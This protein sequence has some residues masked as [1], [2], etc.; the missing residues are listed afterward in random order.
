MDTVEENGRDSPVLEEPFAPLYKIRVADAVKNGEAVQFTIKVHKVKDDEDGFVVRQF[1]DVEWLEHCLVTQQGVSGLIFPPLPP[2]PELDARS[3]EAKSKKQLG[4]ST[5]VIVGDEFQK[6]CRNL[7]KYLRL[8]ISHEVFGKERA[9]EN[10]LTLK[11]TYGNLRRQTELRLRKELMSRLSNVVG[12]VRKGGHR[13]IDEKFQQVRDW[14]S[15]Y[16]SALK[17]DSANFKKTVFA[18]RR[19][20]GAYGH[21]GT[22]LTSTSVYKDESSDKVDKL[23]GC[24][25]EAMND[26]KHGLEVLSTNDEKTLGFQLEFYCRYMDSLKEMLYRR[27]CLLVQYED[28]NKALEKAKPQKRQA[29]EEAQEAAQK[30]YNSCTDMARRELKTFEQERL[31][32]F[33]HGLSA[34]AESQV[35]TARD[36]YA[37]LVKSLAT[38][39]KMDI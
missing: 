29:A 23:M 2:R 11:E 25:A 1:E 22:S 12:E 38:V 39:K 13:D 37:L 4:S 6:D 18:Q 24:L 8:L 36:T 20:A 17:E 27:T 14:S 26:A 19:L 32:A 28:A 5:K 30:A 35:K 10:F 3:A 16:L 7:E 33:Q 21:L 15:E 9:L 31:R 34:Y